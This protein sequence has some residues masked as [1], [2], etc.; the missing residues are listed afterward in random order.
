MRG[1]AR[2]N[3]IIVIPD[4]CAMATIYWYRSRIHNLHALA[5][6]TICTCLQTAHIFGI[7]IRISRKTGSNFYHSH[8]ACELYYIYIGT[9]RNASICA[10]KQSSQLFF[11]CDDTIINRYAM[12]IL[13]VCIA[14]AHA[15]T[16]VF[17][18]LFYLCI[19]NILR[20][21]NLSK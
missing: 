7:P 1:M 5:V 14:D 4:E 20:Q 11:F 17:I 12:I 13:A 2:R 19:Y 18:Y 9:Y 16:S 8:G 6:L 3:I 10:T 21:M 15:N